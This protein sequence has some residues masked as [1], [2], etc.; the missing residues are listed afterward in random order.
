SPADG[1][2]APDL[3]G[4]ICGS[5]RE[6]VKRMA[7]VDLGKLDGASRAHL[8]ECRSRL[9]RALEAQFQRRG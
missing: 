6:L 5:A 7:A 1:A 9:D 4:I 2:V 3:H 8:L